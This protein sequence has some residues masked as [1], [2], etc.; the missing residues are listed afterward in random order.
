[1]DKISIK[2][3][4]LVLLSFMC[5]NCIAQETLGNK[6]TDK[7]GRPIRYNIIKTNLLG[8]SLGMYNIAYE[9]KLGTK[10]SAV[11]EVVVFGS[12]SAVPEQTLVVDDEN[13]MFSY[14]ST[15]FAI[16]PEVRM[17]LGKHGSPRGY[18]LGLYIPIINYNGKFDAKSTIAPALST[19]KTATIDA[20]G[21]F[22]PNFTFYGLGLS[23]GPQFIIANRISLEFYLNIALGVYS[24]SNPDVKIS[25]TGSTALTGVFLNDKQA[26]LEEL[27]ARGISVDTAPEYTYSIEGAPANPTLVTHYNKSAP[28]NELKDYSSGLLVIPRIGFSIGYA[29]GK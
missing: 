8:W 22:T 25:G 16:S 28:I 14:G 5:I 21:S 20:K 7:K 27:E 1:M 24:I 26:T 3:I 18:Y 13:V 9:R 29:F 12:G 2:R 10:Y 23:G 11:M 19:N 6:Y 15:G 17:Y 4:V